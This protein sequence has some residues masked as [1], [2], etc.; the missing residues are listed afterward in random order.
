MRL[1]HGT[2]MVKRKGV[3]AVPHLLYSGAVNRFSNMLLLQPWRELE[4]IQCGQE[5]L[6]TDQQR[7]KRLDLFP[8]CDFKVCHDV[9]EEE[10]NL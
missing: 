1:R 4:T 3:N 9:H 10:E 2:V 8:M 6:E 5:D 7:Q